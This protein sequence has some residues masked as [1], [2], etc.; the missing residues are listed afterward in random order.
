VPA[1]PGL[2]SEHE[3]RALLAAR[4]GAGRVEAEPEAAAELL[5]AAATLAAKTGFDR[6]AWQLP[7][8]MG[9]YLDS[10]EDWQ[11]LAAIQRGALG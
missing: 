7:L 4:L 6:H 9:D 11:E 2:L 1:A 3:A 10:R 5:L 8:T